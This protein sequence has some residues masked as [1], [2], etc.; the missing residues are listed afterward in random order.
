MEKVA[1]IN[2]LSFYAV[3]YGCNFVV[4]RDEVWEL[5]QTLQCSGRSDQPDL[6]QL[7]CPWQTVNL[8]FIEHTSI[9]SYFNYV[10]LFLENN[11][12]FSHWFFHIN[13]WY[14]LYNHLFE[15]TSQFKDLFWVILDYFG[16]HFSDVPLFIVGC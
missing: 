11:S 16:T 4:T 10:H 14:Y 2:F 15:K 9:H 13:F 8:A 5:G 7:N 12:I 1:L 3:W 6:L